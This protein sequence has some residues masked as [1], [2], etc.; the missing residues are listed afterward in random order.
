M[1]QIGQG[2]TSPELRKVPCK[3][4]EMMPTYISMRSTLVVGV[5]VRLHLPYCLD[6]VRVYEARSQIAARG[7]SDAI[8]NTMP[9]NDNVV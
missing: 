3:A 4:R 1:T 6:T 9:M 8:S 2:T 5:K 7:Y